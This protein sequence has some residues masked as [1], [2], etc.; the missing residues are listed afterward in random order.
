VSPLRVLATSGFACACGLFSVTASAE[1]PGRPLVH[2]R[3]DDCADLDKAEVRRTLVGELGALL[4]NDV[5]SRTDVTRTE[6]SCGPAFI[7]IHIL[8][9]I[10]GK[11]LERTIS[12]EESEK[13]SRSRLVGLAAAE[14]VTASWTELLSS[15]KSSVRIVGRDPSLESVVA[16]KSAA[17][18]RVTLKLSPP[19]PLRLMP[20]VAY[21]AF[22]H[23][24]GELWGGGMRIADDR[25][26]WVG[27][28]ADAL[29]E[30]GSRGVSLG[31]VD[32]DTI[33]VSGALLIHREWGAFAFRTGLGLRAGATR[34]QGSPD[35]PNL[36]EGK[37]VYSPWGWPM[38]LMGMS[39]Q[40]IEP[41]VIELSVESGYTVMPMGGVVGGSKEITLDGVWVGG[42][43]GL[44]VKL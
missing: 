27:W 5:S 4:V 6:I 30:H 17:R 8:D 34:L 2:V 16:A 21:R 28:S 29:V 39:I 20:V 26:S 23:G 15:T 22:V 40:P 10:T 9:P 32:I 11:I 12:V 43:I 1:D 31:H 19:H 35:S 36:A 7:T 42:Q 37:S 14:L 3:I 13:N 44:G 33:T 18:D 25:F 24:G 38:A 41:V